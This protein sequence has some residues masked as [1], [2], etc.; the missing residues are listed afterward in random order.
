VCQSNGKSLFLASGYPRDIPGVPREHNFSGISF[1][2]ANMTGFV[3]RALQTNPDSSLE[4]LERSLVAGEIRQAGQFTG[5]EIGVL[6][7][8]L[9]KC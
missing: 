4:S 7:Q 5:V 3:A 6:D 2:I 8:G 9:E 1:A